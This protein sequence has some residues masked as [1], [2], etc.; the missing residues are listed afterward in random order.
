[1]CINYHGELFKPAK[2]NIHKIKSLQF[3]YPIAGSIGDCYVLA[4]WTEIGF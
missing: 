4:I 1:M 2:L 3:L